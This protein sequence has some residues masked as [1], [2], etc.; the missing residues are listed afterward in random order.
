MPV[1]DKWTTF[2]LP[3]FSKVVYFGEDATGALNFWAEV[4]LN[5][6]EES[7]RFRVFGTGHVI[8]GERWI[9]D[10]VATCVT[11][12]FVWHLYEERK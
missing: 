8:D 3:R 11:G 9:P 7:R 1:S 2:N 10:H 5:Q 4:P 6:L 12:P